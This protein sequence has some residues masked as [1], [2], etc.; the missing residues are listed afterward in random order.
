[1]K[2]T[3]TPVYGI[4]ITEPVSVTTP[5]YDIP[6]FGTSVSETSKKKEETII[7]G[8]GVLPPET[9]EI[10]GPVSNETPVYGI[11]LSGLSG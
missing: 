2:I 8:P 6:V 5:V 7:P 3:A 4:K 9:S 10:T 11:P 1:M